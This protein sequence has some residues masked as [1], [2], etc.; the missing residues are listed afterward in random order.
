[1]I[2]KYT[3]MEPA[4]NCGVWWVSVFHLY[5]GFNRKT[6]YCGNFVKVSVRRT[7]P[8][9]WLKK[10]TKVKGI[11]IR[12]KKE[13]SKNDGSW[14]KF[15]DNGIVLLKKRL[16]TQGHMLEGPINNKIKRRKF[17]NAFPGAI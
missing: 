8:D 5:Y 12:T 16:N 17:K 15:T 4:D 1:M 14:I 3:Y 13:F 11:I 10:K 6:A 7:K 9:N 2:K